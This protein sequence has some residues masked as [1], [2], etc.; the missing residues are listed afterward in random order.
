MSVPCRG[1]TEVKCSTK[2]IFLCL[3]ATWAKILTIYWIMKEG[4]TLASR[5][6]LYRNSEEEANHIFI[7]FV[8]AQL[9]WDLLLSLL[10][11][12][13]GQL[14]SLI[15]WFLWVMDKWQRMVWRMTLLCLFLC[16]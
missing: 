13:Q 10:G 3:E 11:C 6:I 5:C 8:Q 14:R 7:H 16:L 9:V 4:L 2:G 12:S 1:I 15:G